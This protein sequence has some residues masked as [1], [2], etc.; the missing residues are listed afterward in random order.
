MDV[1]PHFAM[2]S[3]CS[4][5]LH[6]KV[7]LNLFMKSP[8]RPRSLA[9]LGVTLVVASLVSFANTSWNVVQARGTI[10]AAL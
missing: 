10:R 4:V 3:M 2:Y 5:V 9:V 8:K 7:I 6:N 1:L